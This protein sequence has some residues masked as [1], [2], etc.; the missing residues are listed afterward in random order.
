M[1]YD[2]VERLNERKEEDILIKLASGVNETDRAKG[3]RHAVFEPSFDWKE[4]FTEVFI[5]Q[6]LNY[7]HENPC[8]GKWKVGSQSSRL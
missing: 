8:R 3:Q 1:A 5:L 7:T 6:K 4:C 2:L